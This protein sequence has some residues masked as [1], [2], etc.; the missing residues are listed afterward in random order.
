[1]GNSSNSEPR[2]VP[3]SRFNG[4]ILQFLDNYGKFSGEQLRGWITENYLEQFYSVT[5]TKHSVP[6]YRKSREDL[7]QA[8]NKAHEGGW[9]ARLLNITSVQNVGDR[10]IIKY[11]YVINPLRT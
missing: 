5:Y 7:I 2:K 4:L 10:E 11:K 6:S 1:M 3:E 8:F 9:R